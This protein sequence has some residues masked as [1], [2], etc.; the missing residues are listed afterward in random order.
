M[1]ND[2]TTPMNPG[3]PNN[4]GTSHSVP[5]FQPHA[6]SAMTAPMQ[7]P[8]PMAAAPMNTMPVHPQTPPPPAPMPGSATSTWGSQPLSSQPM[9]PAPMTAPTTPSW[10]PPPPPPPSMTPPMMNNASDFKPDEGKSKL[11]LLIAGILLILAMAGG[12]FLYVLYQ[13]PSQQQ[14]AEM[15]EQ[16]PQPTA[17][18]SP[19][20]T[21]EDQAEKDIEMLNN[22][23]SSDEVEAIQLDVNNT[24]LSTLDR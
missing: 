21:E 4:V 3:V 1:N 7:Q 8:Q 16:V 14:A 5:P 13:T 17:V 24:D 9:T 6:P 11:P 12:Y 19:T 23:S 18:P 15:I 10:T 2:T 22:V 20:M